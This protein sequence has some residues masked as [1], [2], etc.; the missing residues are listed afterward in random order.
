[1]T[2]RIKQAVLATGRA[3]AR[4][5]PRTRHTT[6]A[7]AIDGGRPVRNIRWRPW[8]AE[9]SALRA[10]WNR[11]VGPAFR[12]VFLSGVEGLPQTR[13]NVFASRW[14]ALC[15]CRHG[16]LLPHGTDA[17]RFALAARLE[18]DGLE[19]GGEVIVPNL[20]FIASATAA[21]DRRFGVALVD[22][23][24][25]TLNL[26]PR[27]V[28]EAVQPGVTRAIVPVHQFGQP[29]DMTAL[30]DIATRHGL[31]LIEDAAQAHGAVW[32][33]GPVGSLGDAAAFSFQSAKNLRSGEGGIL[34]TND[35]ALFERAH[36]LHNAGRAYGTG[37]RWEH[38]TLG[39]NCRGTEYQ[40]ALL[41]HRL[42][43]FPNQQ[44]TRKKNFTRLRELLKSVQSVEPQT[45]DPR[46]REHG[47][48]MFVFR[49][50]PDRCGGAP[51]TTFLDAVRAEGA[52]IHRCYVSTIAEQPAVH[53]LRAH[54]PK[55]VRV[56]P[57]PVS[58][59]AV[60]NTLYIASSIFLGESGDMDDIV[61]AIEKVER[62]LRA[63]AA[64]KP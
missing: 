16:L 28:E 62:A 34:T 31:A 17:L 63:R 30:R 23:E 26:D 25:G 33:S 21:W 4:R 51:L 5:L 52:P 20:S 64:S 53:D 13:Q 7:L 57:T 41:L 61:A 9:D 42:D 56:M 29:A 22:V 45:I 24:E 49:Y 14:A 40:A 46:V 8:A 2:T 11:A 60:T 38:E 3:V 39:W 15:G 36:A 6:G 35:T 12:E 37:G 19:Y 59:H 27:R 47:M 55:Y 10:Q 54:R 1:M 18:H 43:L 58:D 44:A 48:Y 32:E 50:Q